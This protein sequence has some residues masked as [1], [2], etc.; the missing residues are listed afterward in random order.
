MPRPMSEAEYNTLS[1]RLSERPEEGYI[2]DMEL[3][4]EGLKLKPEKHDETMDKKAEINFHELEAELA[5]R[6]AE[7]Q[8][9]KS[10]ILKVL[11]CHQK[12]PFEPALPECPLGRDCNTRCPWYI[13]SEA[14][15]SQ[16]LTAIAL[17]RIS[18]IL[19]QR[20]V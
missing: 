3:F 12:M 16:K 2:S 18:N 19:G 14:M 11:G 5:A 7:A 10:R 20:R 13:E 9:E 1:W 15:C 17:N 8:A 4:E 6:R